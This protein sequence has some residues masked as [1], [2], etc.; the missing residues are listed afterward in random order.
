MAQYVTGASSV[1]QERIESLMVL[2]YDHT[3]LSSGSHGP[4]S[5]K[6]G[7]YAYEVNRTMSD[8]QP[9][10]NTKTIDVTVRWREKG[11]PKSLSLAYIKMDVI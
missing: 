3:E 9:I 10:D 4:E 6:L 11:V 8:D 7:K 1:G 2:P 5:V